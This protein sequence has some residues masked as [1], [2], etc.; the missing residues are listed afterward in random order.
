MLLFI[1]LL[2]VNNIFKSM[3]FLIFGGVVF[4][5]FLYLDLTVHQELLTSLAC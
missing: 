5:I 2:C 3:I 1:H 4:V